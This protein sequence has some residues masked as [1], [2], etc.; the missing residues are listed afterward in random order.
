[1]SAPQHYT[2]HAGDMWIVT[3][4]CH[5]GTRQWVANDPQLAYDKWLEAHDEEGLL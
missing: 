4:D 5:R 3:C 2:T 1:M